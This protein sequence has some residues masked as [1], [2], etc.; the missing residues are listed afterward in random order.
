M[1]VCVRVCVCVGGDFTFQSGY[2]LDELKL[3]LIILFH[4]TISPSLNLCNV[5]GVAH[6]LKKLGAIMEH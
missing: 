1:C 5:N 4:E 6:G 3:H 2:G